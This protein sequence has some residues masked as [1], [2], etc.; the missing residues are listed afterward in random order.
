MPRA[1]NAAASGP[2]AG[3]R[4]TNSRSDPTKWGRTA[5]IDRSPPLRVPNS[6]TN[7][8]RG[9]FLS[10][11]AV[12]KVRSETEK[13]AGEGASANRAGRLIAGQIARTA[14]EIERGHE[15][16][17]LPDHHPQLASDR[18]KLPALR[19]P[20]LSGFDC[21]HMQANRSAD[22]LAGRQHALQHRLQGFGRWIVS[23]RVSHLGG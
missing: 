8:I 1:P 17:S 21:L 10:L 9:I 19:D 20:L 13:L 7:R 4:A 11:Y 14:F 2:I 12:V 5:S 6:K 3:A 16:L 23:V 18:E 15:S 22:F